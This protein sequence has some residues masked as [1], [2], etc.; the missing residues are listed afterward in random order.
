MAQGGWRT[1]ETM[2]TVYLAMSRSEVQQEIHKAANL[3]GS[4]LVLKKAFALWTI[5][6]DNFAAQGINPILQ[7]ITVVQHSIDAIPWDKMIE[8]KIGVLLKA[9]VGH[10]DKEVRCK[11]TW[12]SNLLRSK[13]AAHQSA[14]RNIGIKQLVGNKIHLS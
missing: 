7:F 5:N 3:G 11:A 1:S 2:K 13:F 14:N 10:T 12:T 4:G 8:F 6:K 9:L